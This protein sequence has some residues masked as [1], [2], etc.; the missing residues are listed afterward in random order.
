MKPVELLGRLLQ[1]GSPIRGKI[2]DPFIGSGST[3]VAAEQTGRSCF[4]IEIEPRYCAVTL[5]RMSEM[6][7]EP[8]RVSHGA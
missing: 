7:L 5:H 6:G 3:M 1:D 2:Y 4:G 8:E